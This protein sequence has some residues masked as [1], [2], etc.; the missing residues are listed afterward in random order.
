MP[1]IADV[2]GHDTAMSSTEPGEAATGGR[3][4]RHGIGVECGHSGSESDWSFEIG[5]ASCR[6]RMCQYV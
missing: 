1:Q 6:E 3:G 2:G 5:R 4:V